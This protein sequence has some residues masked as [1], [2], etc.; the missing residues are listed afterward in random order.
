MS[1]CDIY[2]GNKNLILNFAYII[3]NLM[4]FHITILFKSIFKFFFPSF[5]R[6]IPRSVKYLSLYS[7]SFFYYLK[8]NKIKKEYIILFRLLVFSSVE[9]T[10]SS[11]NQTKL[12][13]NIYSMYNSVSQIFFR[14]LFTHTSTLYEV[15]SVLSVQFNRETL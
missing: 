8:L 5:V 15:Y 3:N 9:V 2:K 10:V 4:S 13:N 1:L 6:S 14:P 7:P 11:M 12:N